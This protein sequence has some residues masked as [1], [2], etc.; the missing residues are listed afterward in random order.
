MPSRILFSLP[1]LFISLLVLLVCDH[2][3]SILALDA[4]EIVALK[5]MQ[6][7]WGS[8]LGWTGNPSCNWQGIQCDNAGNVFDMILYSQGLTGMIPDSIG[9][10]F[11]L[12]QLYVS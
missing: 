7:E 12:F 2:C 5:D 3:G 9:N 10:L 1:L 11:A 6:A 8:Q 4:G